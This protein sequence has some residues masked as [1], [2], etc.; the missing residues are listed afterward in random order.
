MLHRNFNNAIQCGSS[1]LDS[2]EFIK[3]HTPRI[4]KCRLISKFLYRISLF[5]VI[6]KKRKGKFFLQ[7][8]RKNLV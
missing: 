3:N 2:F 1:K 5:D 7:F 4:F 6:K 8:D